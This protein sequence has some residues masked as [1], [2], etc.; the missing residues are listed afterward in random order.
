VLDEIDQDLVS[1]FDS[2]VQLA[3]VIVHALEKRT[4][5]EP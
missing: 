2:C 1:L 3:V 5:F 4:V